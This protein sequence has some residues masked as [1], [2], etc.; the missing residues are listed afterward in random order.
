MPATVLFPRL[1]GSCYIRTDFEI[2]LYWNARKL[3]DLNVAIIM[4][5][6]AA[7]TPAVLKGAGVTLQPF[8]SEK[9][10]PSTSWALS[11]PARHGGTSPRLPGDP[12]LYP[13][14]VGDASMDHEAPTVHSGD[15]RIAKRWQDAPTGGVL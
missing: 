1:A 8:T 10:Y 15:L 4:I 9:G 2:G 7:S 14:K 6:K 5:A 3:G 11:V 13:G 12:L